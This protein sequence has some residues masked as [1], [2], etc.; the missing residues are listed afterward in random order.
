MSA[1][2]EEAP[3]GADAAL[4]ELL[5]ELHGTFLRYVAFPSPAAADAVACGRRRRTP[6]RHGST[7][8]GW[9]SPRR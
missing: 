6:S 3:A 8:P 1:Y 9:S 5:D 4:G 7:P 2:W